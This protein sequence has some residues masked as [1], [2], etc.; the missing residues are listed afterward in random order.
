MSFLN[1]EL[2]L[3]SVMAGLAL[4]L[5]RPWKYDFLSLFNVEMQKFLQMF[6]WLSAHEWRKR[7][8]DT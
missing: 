2:A 4:W 8:T 1:L 6:V 7:V 5:T 3:F